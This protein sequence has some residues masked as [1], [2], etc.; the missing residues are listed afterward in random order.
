MRGER[1]AQSKV[2]LL[3]CT[4]LGSY[5][6]LDLNLSKKIKRALIWWMPAVGFGRAKT[7]Q[8]L[9]KET[10]VQF[11]NLRVISEREASQVSK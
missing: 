4:K 7:R 8:I 5:F 1:S 9:R 3:S 10:Q 11:N 2:R 6:S